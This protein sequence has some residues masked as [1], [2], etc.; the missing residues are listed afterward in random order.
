MNKE[1]KAG[2]KQSRMPRGRKRNPDS[3]REVAQSV[4]PSQADPWQRKPRWTVPQSQLGL[5]GWCLF[6]ATLMSGRKDYLK[7]TTL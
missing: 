2:A 4:L 7:Y 1:I 3:A 5:S 6:L